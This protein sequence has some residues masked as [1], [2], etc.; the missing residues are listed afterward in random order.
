MVYVIHLYAVTKY[1]I[2]IK[3]FLIVYKALRSSKPIVNNN[4]TYVYLY[5]NHDIHTVKGIHPP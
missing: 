1:L 2:Y 3:N 5:L 4:I